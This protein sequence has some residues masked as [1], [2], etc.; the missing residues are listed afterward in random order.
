MGR[1][2]RQRTELSVEERSWR[3]GVYI[4]SS[5]YLIE[6][7]SGH[8]VL[9]RCNTVGYALSQLKSFLFLRYI[10][11]SVFFCGVEMLICA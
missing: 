8:R 5:G 1:E 3:A 10:A 2:D 7:T 11:A 4:L 9:G 6:I